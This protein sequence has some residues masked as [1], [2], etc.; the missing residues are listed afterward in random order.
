MRIWFTSKIVNPIMS[1]PKKGQCYRNQC[2]KQNWS[3]TEN[4]LH[5]SIPHMALIR[6]AQ[7]KGNNVQAKEAAGLRYTKAQGGTLF[8]AKGVKAWLSFILV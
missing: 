4:A 3:V 7:D 5:Y 2:E 6:A 8:F 1:G